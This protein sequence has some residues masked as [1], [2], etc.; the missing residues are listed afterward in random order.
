M[1]LFL[2]FFLFALFSVTRRGANVVAQLVNKHKTKQMDECEERGR[3]AEAQFEALC[4]RRQ[5]R[6]RKATPSEDAREHWDYLVQR[7]A[8]EAPQ[9]VEVK[10]EKKVKRSDREPSRVFTWLE[11]EGVPRASGEP[12][13]GWLRGRADWI[14]F[15][16]HT[17][18]GQL[19]FLLCRRVDCLA[20]A[21]RHAAAAEAAGDVHSSGAPRLHALYQRVTRGEPR[22][23]MILVQLAELAA[24]PQACFL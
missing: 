9:R 19:G 5:W 20:L 23:T 2:R 8:Q 3:G 14:A 7:S 12:N 6:W 1:A 22:G 24:L 17:P 21:E 13:G 18:H 16:C 10:A 4:A 15:H 11:W